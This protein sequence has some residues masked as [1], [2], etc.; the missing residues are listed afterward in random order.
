MVSLVQMEYQESVD[1]KESKEQLVL[2][3]I[4]ERM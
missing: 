1:Q 4:L 3:D 2:M